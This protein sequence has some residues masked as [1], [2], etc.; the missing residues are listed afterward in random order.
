MTAP[1]MFSK[2][3]AFHPWVGDRYHSN[4]PRMLVIG[5]SHYEAALSESG[6]TTEVVRRQFGAGLDPER[7]FQ[8]YRSLSAIERAVSGRQDLAQDPSR[9]FWSSVSLYNFVQAELADVHVRPTSQQFSASVDAF[10]EVILTLEPEVVVVFGT[11][12]W[13]HLPNDSRI[14]W[15]RHA[16]EDAPDSPKARF[17]RVLEIWTTKV[18]VS[19][20]EHVFWCTHFPH[21]SSRGFGSGL[22]WNPWVTTLLTFIQGKDPALVHANPV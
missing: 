19:D 21:P 11:Q 8:R 12:T 18:T 1:A 6:V 13:N 16:L 4:S 2:L 17:K 10:C 20:R 7:T 5:E 9:R 14:Q 15:R 3:V 22:D